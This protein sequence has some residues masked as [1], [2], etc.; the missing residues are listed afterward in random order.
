V[1]PSTGDNRA[2]TSA[3]SSRTSSSA[4]R[5]RITT[6]SK[7]PLHDLY[8]RVPRTSSESKKADARKSS[9]SWS[10]ISNRYDKRLET[11]RKN[12]DTTRIDRKSDTTS[13]GAGPSKSE[14]LTHPTDGHGRGKTPAVKRDHS[15]RDR[16][17]DGDVNLREDQKLK[18]RT[19]GGLSDRYGQV[20]PTKKD[21]RH[22]APS[23]TAGNERVTAVSASGQHSLP[24]DLRPIGDSVHYRGRSNPTTTYCE[25]SSYYNGYANWYGQSLGLAF[26]FGYTP[27]WCRWGLY[28]YPY[29]YCS[30]WPS[31][32]YNYSYGFGVYWNSS[33]PWYSYSS[34]WWPT[35]YYQPTVYISHRYYGSVYGEESEGSYYAA[36]YGGAAL[37]ADEAE[38]LEPPPSEVSVA[39]HH[40]SLGDF[41]FK[42]GR[43]QEAAESY[44]RV[45]AYAPED[46]SIHFVVA[47]ALF[48]VGDYHY[49]AYMIGKGL[50]FDPELAHVDVDKRSY[51]SDPATFEAQMKTL[52]AYVA[53]KPYDAAA[54]IVL[55]YNLNFSGARDEAALIFQHVMEISP[56]NEV[57]QSF[58]AG[59]EMAREAK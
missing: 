6:G 31:W 28:S 8:R 55:A 16:G 23:K 18:P 34:C 46:A 20:K 35:S 44:L 4:P 49:A 56:S 14:P 15:R 41:Y 58:L 39:K 32:Y 13:R 45:L 33:Y 51:Y 52:R 40:V 3:G 59:I 37:A 1:T 57:A 50:R 9:R 5:P 19:R 36:S 38:G 22:A 11:N 7:S 29:Y 42:E 43:F 10:S 30:Y 12:V 17:R 53:E 26:S 21:D 27:S 48:A 54:H 47:D 24:T 2:R 25:P